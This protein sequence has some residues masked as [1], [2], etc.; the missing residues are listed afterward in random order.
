MLRVTMISTMPVAMTAIEV[1]CT[2]RFHRL[3]EVMNFPSDRALKPIQMTARATT[4]PSSR[5]SIPLDVTKSR[6]D[7]DVRSALAGVDGGC[8]RQSSPA[9][10]IA[11]PLSTSCEVL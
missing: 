1:L 5:V 4:M 11:I 6:H 10:L 9:T 8:G 7:R 3:R 2:D